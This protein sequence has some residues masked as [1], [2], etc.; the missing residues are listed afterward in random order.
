MAK[1]T[2]FAC[3]IALKLQV[4]SAPRNP[5]HSQ[6]QQSSAMGYYLSQG[7][8]F[9]QEAAMA[10]MLGS[11]AVAVDAVDHLQGCL[12]CLEDR[13]AV[14]A[15][16]EVVKETPGKEAMDVAMAKTAMAVEVIAVAVVVAVMAEAATAVMAAA[17]AAA[18]EVVATATE[19]VEE[20][21]AEEAVVVAEAVE[22]VVVVEAVKV[23]GACGIRSLCS[24]ST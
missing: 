12:L 21:K 5:P 17:V 18:T 13:V 23:E 8:R 3:L 14:A 1:Y 11:M 4:Q 7:C 2:T 15:A 19:A 9:V 20:A 22:E 6:L 10:T 24:P 16:K